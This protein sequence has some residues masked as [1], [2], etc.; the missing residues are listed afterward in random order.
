M[1]NTLKPYVR[2]KVFG[3]PKAERGFEGVGVL[4]HSCHVSEDKAQA[5][6]GLERWGIAF[7]KGVEIV[8]RWVS[9]RHLLPKV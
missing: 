9:P 1:D 5:H 2:V 4:V 3:D 7:P 6:P 8:N